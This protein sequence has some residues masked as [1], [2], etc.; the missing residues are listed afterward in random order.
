MLIRQTSVSIRFFFLTL[1]SSKVTGFPLALATIQMHNTEVIL[2]KNTRLDPNSPIDY[3][4]P[5]SE[6]VW[7]GLVWFF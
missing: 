3:L 4:F 2:A 5:I 6:V 7:F 1:Y